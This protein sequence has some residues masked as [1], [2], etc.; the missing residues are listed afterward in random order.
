MSSV[1]L[2]RNTANTCSRQQQKLQWNGAVSNSRA[3]MM[4][5]PSWTEG[6][7]LHS[8]RVSNELQIGL[9]LLNS[10]QDLLFLQV[11]PPDPPSLI[12]NPAPSPSLEW[13]F[14]RPAG[15]L[16]D[17]GNVLFP[18]SKGLCCC[19]CMGASNNTG[20]TFIL[21]LLVCHSTCSSD[22]GKAKQSNVVPLKK[23]N[24]FLLYNTAMLFSS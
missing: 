14:L 16:T 10:Q 22:K 23:N 15:T 9:V 11:C 18:I 19:A 5:L 4:V 7:A 2:E 3:W 17:R 20:T 12:F 8:S 21:I 24:L 6:R 13:E 1:K